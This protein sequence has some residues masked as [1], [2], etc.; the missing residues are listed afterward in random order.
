MALYFGSR[1]DTSCLVLRSHMSFVPGAHESGCEYPLRCYLCQFTTTQPK[2]LS[3]HECA[4][5]WGQYLCLQPGC[6]RSYWCSYK[7]R[8]HS[9]K[10]RH[11]ISARFSHVRTSNSR[12]GRSSNEPAIST[13]SATAVAS[14]NSASGNA[15]HSRN[16]ASIMAISSIT[17]CEY[18]HFFATSLPSV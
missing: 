8:K 16:E 1:D 9:R 17:L 7:L 12:V 13:L 14:T 11:C 2:E 18:H 4:A 6:N 10:R 3:R 5:H 15:A